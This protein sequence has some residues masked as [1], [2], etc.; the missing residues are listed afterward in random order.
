MLPVMP[1]GFS[2]NMPSI[3]SAMW[4]TDEYAPLQP[5]VEARLLVRRDVERVHTRLRVVREVQREDAEQHH[6]AADE[7]V[8]EEL[9]RRV[10]AVRA[11]PDADEEIH[12]L[13]DHFPEQEEEQE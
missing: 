8:E 4:L 11:A 1:T 12:R 6:D 3:T 13:Q 10:E 2:A 9:D 5:G 7:R